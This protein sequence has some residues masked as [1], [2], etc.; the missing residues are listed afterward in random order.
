MSS[1]PV[2]YG[3][4]S[5]VSVRLSRMATTDSRLPSAVL[6]CR[7]PLQVSLWQ[8][9][10]DELLLV[11]ASA[12]RGFIRDRGSASRPGQCFSIGTPASS[13]SASWYCVGGGDFR[14]GS[15]I[16]QGLGGLS[17]EL[18]EHEPGPAP[19]SGPA[20][21]RSD[22]QQTLGHASAGFTL[23]AY[24]HLFDDDLDAL[25]DALESTS[26]VEAPYRPSSRIREGPIYRLGCRGSRGGTRTTTTD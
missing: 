22:A 18:G 19:G 10:V 9:H 3:A 21:K 13:T 20:V 25:A 8:L 7:C 11:S 2:K 23:T 17:L 6:A 4:A 12:D 16:L 5:F 26:A 1:T 14:S 15:Q 24:G